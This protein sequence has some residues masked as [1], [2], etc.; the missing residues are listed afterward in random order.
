MG[1]FNSH[2]TVWSFI[3]N[4]LSEPWQR[5]GLMSFICHE[6]VLDIL[7]VISLLFFFLQ[8]PF[9]DLWWTYLRWL[10]PDHA[11]SIY[12]KTLH[13]PGSPG[14]HQLAK[15]SFRWPHL[16]VVLHQNLRKELWKGFLQISKLWFLD[17]GW[18]NCTRSQFEGLQSL[19]CHVEIRRWHFLVLPYF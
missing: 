16:H 4:G 7:H 3:L 19:H 11:W 6:H 12:S 9:W 14:S 17:C 8:N 10:S 2:E 1:I 13:F 18:E 15:C 5:E